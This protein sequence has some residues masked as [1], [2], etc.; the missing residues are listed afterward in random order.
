MRRIFLLILLVISFNFLFSQQNAA[1]M[2]FSGSY[3]MRSRGIDCIFWN[4]ANLSLMNSYSSQTILPFT[5]LSLAIDNN[6]VSL[7]R[8][9]DIMG[10]FIT[11]SMKQ[12]IYKDLNSSWKANADFKSTFFAI[13]FKNSA[14]ALTSNLH[15]KGRLSEE[16]IKLYLSG[17][18]IDKVYTFTAEN[19][20]FSAV[21]TLELSYARG[22]TSINNLL[23]FLKDKDFPE[24]RAGF[25][26]HLIYGLAGAEMTRFNGTFVTDDDGL[27][28]NQEVMFR[29]GMDGF[30]F[31][32]TLAL[33]TEINQNFSIGLQMKNLLGF[34]KWLGQTEENYGKFSCEDLFL[35]D[36]SEDVIVDEN[37]YRKIDSYT[38]QL[39]IVLNLAGLYKW[40]N[41]SLSLDW[42]QGFENSAVS[43]KQ[44]EISLGA[45]YLITQRFPLRMGF[46]FG[47]ENHNYKISYGT[48]YIGRKVEF[49]FAIQSAHALIPCSY[50]RN[51]AFAFQTKLNI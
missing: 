2:S 40:Q 35:A 30:G 9:N 43:V 13:Y 25:A 10:N 36:L 51:I 5:N 1:S 32:S 50:S 41:Y 33:A 4:P 17:N 15:A 24:I 46:L 8:Y 26:I 28:L 47:N 42:E 20:D 19:N 44:P 34:V 49:I 14:I 7:N 38:T 6:A 3:L 22:F 27:N 16:Y 12:S 39:P 31:R 23:W 37:W 18:Q 21:S 48:G 29:T 11:E 45:E